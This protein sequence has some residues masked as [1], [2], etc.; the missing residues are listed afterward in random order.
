MIAG[1]P[2]QG[3]LGDGIN[4]LPFSNTKLLG[5]KK[6]EYNLKERAYYL[7]GVKKDFPRESRSPPKFVVHKGPITLTF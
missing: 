4:G 6:L 7:D 5:I 1:Q 2:T 3:I